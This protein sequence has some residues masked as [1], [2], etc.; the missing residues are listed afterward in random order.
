M[1]KTTIAPEERDEWR[2]ECERMT[3]EYSCVD[4]KAQAA[5]RFGLTVL[6][7]LE[8]TEKERDNAVSDR[9][10]LAIVLGNETTENNVNPPCQTGYPCPHFDDGGVCRKPGT[11]DLDLPTRIIQKFADCWCAFVAAQRRGAV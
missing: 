3:H 7:A 9:D 2:R 6:D 4:G 1:S 8:A 10:A 5:L 11:S